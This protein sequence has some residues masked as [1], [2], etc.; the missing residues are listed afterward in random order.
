MKKRTLLDFLTMTVVVVMSMVLTACPDPDDPS[1]SVDK[2]S[3]TLAA[4]GDGDKDI[5]VSA[6]HTDWT[7]SVTEGSSWLRVNKNGQLATISVDENRTSASRTGKIKIVATKDASLYYEVSV[8]QAGADGTISVSVDNVEFGPK[9]GT[10]TI[11]VMS[12]SAWNMSGNQAWLTV[13]PTSSDAPASG[14]ES[15]DVTLKVGENTTNDAQSCTL[16]FTTKDGKGSATVTVRQKE[17]TPF[18]LVNGL[19]STNLTFGENVGIEYQ[20]T[21]SV[22]SNVAWSASG[23]PSWLSVSPINGNGTVQMA[24]YP[25]SVNNSPDDRTATIILSGNGA[26]AQ[27]MV[28]QKHTLSNVKVTPA[29]VVALYNCIGFELEETGK[30]NEFHYLIISDQ[31]MNRLT[32]NELL[33][34]LL[35]EE[36]KKYVDDYMMFPFQ[37]SN[38]QMIKENTKY[39]ICT[40]ADDQNERRGEVVKTEVTTPVYLNEEND[41]WTAFTEVSYVMSAGFYFTLKKQ[42]KCDTYH[43]IYGNLPSDYYYSPACFAFEI[44]YYKKYGRK[45]WFSKNWELE[46]VTDYPND[47]TFTYY[48][49]TLER[50]PLI[51]IYTR[52]VFRDGKES[53]DCYGDQWLAGQD[54]TPRKIKRTNKSTGTL[55]IKR[56][57]EVARAK[58]FFSKYKKR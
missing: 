35:K 18:V 32:N 9:G 24:I 11:S 16:S 37:D 53:S 13:S 36:A 26:S 49:N 34:K 21:V 38:E 1:L 4:N 10:Q 7:A 40:V 25:T 5:S 6:S 3:V 44:N 15:K 55:V 27:I 58:K 48:T 33:N 12:N 39:W 14:S 43:V 54:G 42:G 56:S 45:H 23:I 30:V 46:I 28:T 51:T 47:H 22:S 29:N 31:E 2:T 57:E 8:N 19:E 17:P 41:A 50:Y 52:G 20:Q